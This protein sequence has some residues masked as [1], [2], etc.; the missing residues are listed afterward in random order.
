VCSSD[1]DGNDNI[2][3][4]A[5]INQQGSNYVGLFGYVGS[6][7]Q[8]FNLGV[9]DVNIIGIGSYC[10]GGL[11]GQNDYGTLTDCYT[12][13]SVKGGSPVGGLVGE[14]TGIM[15]ASGTITGCYSTCSISTTWDYSGG[16]VGRNGPGGTLIGCYATGSVST[17]NGLASGLVG[18][19]SG[20]L[21]DCFAT[22]SVTAKNNYVGG[23]VGWNDDG[24]LTA[25]YA[26]GSVT[27]NVSGYHQDIGGLVG[28]NYA[29][30]ITACYATGSV[31]GYVA[32]GGLVGS[33]EGP[34]TDCYSIG[35]VT[36][37]GGLGGIGGL[38]GFN[39]GSI[40]ACFWDI[41]TSGQTT[42]TGGT[43][44]TTAEM[45]TLS[46]FAGE[47]WDFGTPVWIYYTNGYPRLAWEPALPAGDL[48]HDKVVN[49][50]DFAIFAEHWLDGI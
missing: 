10:V 34:L 7:G 50:L 37:I 44:K 36:G 9:V 45:Q 47:G 20:T 11:V 6:D 39:V 1:L 28:Y 17:D 23:L 21:T 48:N 40:T 19:N 12:T 26:T 46:T 42:S 14:N 31:T 27:V 18:W 29:G 16:L 5:L 8:I 35:S 2:I 41:E 49:F 25:C 4:N 32:V 22:G 30:N 43:G 24:T 33:S 13:G 15:Y 38:V 3:S